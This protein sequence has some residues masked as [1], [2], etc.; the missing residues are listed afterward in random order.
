MDSLDWP[1]VC[2]FLL[3]LRRDWLPFAFLPDLML[4]RNFAVLFS[5]L[6]ASPVLLRLTSSHGCIKHAWC[7]F[8]SVYISGLPGT[9]KSH[10]VRAVLASLKQQQVSGAHARRACQGICL[11]RAKMATQ[12]GHA[13]KNSG[14]ACPVAHWAFFLGLTS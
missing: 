1:I 10:T 6:E 12:L 7:S 11:V 4:A 9:G 8:R 13:I 3:M 5:L 2:F 14:L